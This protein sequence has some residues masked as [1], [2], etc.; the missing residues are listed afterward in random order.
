MTT[1]AIEILCIGNEL[2]SGITVNTNAHWLSQKITESGHTSDN[3]PMLRVQ[4]VSRGKNKSEV[5]TRV[6]LYLNF[7]S[8]AIKVE[9]SS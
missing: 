1:F 3:K 8:R 6:R 7:S 5:E 2:L 9:S 4:I